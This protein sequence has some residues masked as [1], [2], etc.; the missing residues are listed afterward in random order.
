MNDLSNI[1]YTEVLT[2]CDGIKSNTVKTDK[3]PVNS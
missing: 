1:Y 3:C 2:Q